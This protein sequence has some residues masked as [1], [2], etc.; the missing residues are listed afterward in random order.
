MEPILVWF[1]LDLRLQDHPALYQ[2]ATRGSVVCVFIEDLNDPW[3]PGKASR[4]WLLESLKH[5]ADK[6]RKAGGELLFLQGDP[7]EKLNWA[8]KKT[9]AKAIFWNQSY[10]PYSKKRDQAI[11]LSFKRKGVEVEVFQ[12]GLLFEPEKISNQSGKPFQVYSAFWKHCLAKETVIEPTPKPKKISFYPLKKIKGDTLPTQKEN[13]EVNWKVGEEE[14]LKK[15]KLFLTKKGGVYGKERDIPSKEGTSYLSPHLHFGEISPRQIWEK[16][17]LE[18]HDKF[19]SELGW[20]EFSYYLLFHH[21]NLPTKAFKK[22]FLAFPYENNKKWL[23]AWKKGMTGYPFVDAGMRELDKTGYMHNRVRMVVASFLTK[24]L[25]I[26]WKEGARWFWEHLVDADLANNSA[27]WQWVAG[28]GADAAPYFRIF[29]PVLQGEKF[30]PE[31]VYV[32]TWVPELKDVNRKWIHRPWEASPLDL[33]QWGVCLGKDYPYPIV[34]H[35]QQ[36]EKALSLYQKLN[37]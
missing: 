20:R 32:K 19:L 7:L 24:D 31:G 29:N 2:A 30:D 9:G 33:K 1:R 3:K 11:A 36:R 26:S 10:E 12:G 37:R 17:G 18:K 22:E 15:I 27:S 6:L 5:F 23:Q 4:W 28:S 21:P 14:A 34:D 13:F 35:K 8:I 25:L 16:A